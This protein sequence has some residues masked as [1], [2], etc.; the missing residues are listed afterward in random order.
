MAPVQTTNAAGRPLLVFEQEQQ[1][2]S[3][4]ARA[5]YW[6][7]VHSSID[8]CERNYAVSFYVA[9]WFNTWSNVSMVVLGL[10]SVYLHWRERS[11]RRYMA[12]GFTL[13]LIG[14]GSAAFHGTLTHIGQQGDETPMVIGSAVWLWCLTFHDPAFEARHPRLG[15]QVAYVFSVL[16]G[17]FAVAHYVYS[18]VLVFQGLI[19]VM[20]VAMLAS[21]SLKWRRARDPALARPFALYW[22]TILVAFPLWLCDQHFCEHLHALPAG[23]PNP[24]FHAWWHL[25]MGAN[26]YL[27]PVVEEP[28]RLAA[29]GRRPRVCWLG[30]C[31]PYVASRHEE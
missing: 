7:P 13:F 26:C 3:A 28:I 6:G 29:K 19:A 5:G 11:E 20:V 8:W 31:V 14:V 21:L 10:V 23:L 16:V 9:E 22:V 27:G 17:A 4:S 15:K 12:T 2:R 25:L 24:Q 18:F 1:Y 30:G